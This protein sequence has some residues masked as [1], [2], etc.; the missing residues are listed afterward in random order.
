MNV[1]YRGRSAYLPD[2]DAVIVADLHVGRSEASAVDAPL[3]D[4]DGVIERLLDHIDAFDPE[5]LVVAGDVL[6]VHGSVPTGASRIVGDLFDR[7]ARRDVDLVL[8]RGNHDT[9]LDALDVVPDAAV[10]DE[11]RLSDETLVCHGHEPPTDSAPRYVVGHEH[12]AILVEGARHPCFLVGDGVYE[13]GDVLVLPAFSLAARG[14]LV[15]GLGETMSPLVGDLGHFRPIVVGS[16]SFE[17][18]PLGEF[19]DLL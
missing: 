6:H 17:F 2:A 13:G 1:E 5:V 14:V 18:P 16:E 10:T 9:I 8:T 11:Y 12:P 4:H 15:N 7:L 3:G 19:V